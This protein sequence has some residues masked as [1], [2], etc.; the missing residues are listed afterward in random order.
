MNI[1]DI[2]QEPVWNNRDVVCDEKPKFFKN[3]IKSNILY[4][5]HLFTDNG[6]KSMDEIGNEV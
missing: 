5:K 4:V 6:F 1:N 2:L 3:G